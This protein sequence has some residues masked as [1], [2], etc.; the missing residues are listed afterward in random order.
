MGLVSIYNFNSFMETLHCV[1]P[2]SDCVS[3]EMWNIIRE[4]AVEKP[5]LMEQR[6]EKTGL[7]QAKVKRTVRAR[8]GF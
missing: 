4:L 2:Y 3:E 7:L 8:Q 5:P 1:P 6:G